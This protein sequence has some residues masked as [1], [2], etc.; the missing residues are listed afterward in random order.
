M[1]LLSCCS[2]RKAR[3]KR[4]CRIW[5]ALARSHARGQARRHAERIKRMTLGPSGRRQEP[6]YIIPM[7]LALV[8]AAFLGGALG[9][10]WQAAGFG[11]K[12]QQSAPPR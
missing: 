1:I 6:L 9:L 4:Q 8:L 10:V 3:K 2:G 7:A 5:M 11:D 12:P